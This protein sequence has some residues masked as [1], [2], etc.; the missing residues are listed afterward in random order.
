MTRPIALLPHW[1]EHL[2]LQTLKLGSKEFVKLSSLQ[3]YDIILSVSTA[4]FPNA[5]ITTSRSSAIH[6]APISQI[7]METEPTIFEPEKFVVA[8]TVTLSTEHGVKV[9]L[10]TE[11]SLRNLLNISL[12][13]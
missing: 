11:H 8:L 2:T 3:G 6:H 10:L 9:E 13:T 7:Q 4:L 5:P 12:N 1:E